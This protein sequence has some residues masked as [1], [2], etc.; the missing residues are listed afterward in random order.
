M[1]ALLNLQEYDSD[2]KDDESGNEI[3]EITSHLQPIKN[4]ANSLSSSIALVAAPA[5]VSNE[6]NLGLRHID[7]KTKEL[8][9]NPKHD[10]LFAPQV[11]PFNPFRTQQA[12]AVRN[13]LA[14]FA[15]PAHFSDFQFDNQRKTFT[16]YGFALDP[17]VDSGNV[18]ETF[19]GSES[20]VLENHGKTVFE[21]NAPIEKDKKKRKR[22]K[23]KDPSDIEGYLGP[24]A[25][26]KDEETVSRPSEEEQKELDEILAKRNKSGKQ[27]EEKTMEEKSTLHV[28]DAYDYQGRSFLHPPQD[29]GVNLKSEEPPEKC[30]LP[31][32]LIHTWTGHT[33]GIAAIRWF[34]KYAHLILSAGM[35]CKIKIWEVYKERRCIRTYTGHKQAVRDVCFNNDG[36][37]FLSCGYD[38]YCKLWDTETGECKARFT[39]RKVP[40][41]IKFH[42]E[43]DKQHL[44]VAGT[45][46][47][48]I[49]CW[50]IR[51]GEIIQEYDRHLG[52]VN[53]ITFI[54]HNRRFVST[55]DDKSLRVWEWDIPVDFKY[56]ADPSMHSMPA[57][58]LSPNGKWLACQSMDNKICVFNALNRMK[59]IRKK[60][61]TGHMV[62]GYA[63][64]IDFS[65]EMSY[66]TCGDAD[67]KVYIW[68][69]RS[70]K[71][72]SKF[73]AHDD[74]C[75]NV[76]WH[77]HETSKLAT[78]GW[79]GVIK[80]WD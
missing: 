47:K 17:S 62:A 42:P 40:Y 38:R 49:V 1:A 27:T 74:V 16:S 6:D 20:S 25:K 37:E 67:G 11:G 60:T 26:Y 12:K 70:T 66:I 61:F 53:S 68:D 10:E 33:K 45:S 54:D 43:E 4:P 48:K 28:K 13:N 19:V 75:I 8:K 58:T 65:P 73:K 24:W 5:V 29:V 72:Y 51:S 79:D 46:D 21:T 63:C 39:S 3:S 30:F 57:V 14:G 44:F 23:N 80:F 52:P 18:I 15:E 7:P 64:G 56:I 32:K 31:K 59:F 71:L 9:Y 41:C 34:P 55:S 22:E 78:A 2:D 36:K 76:L 69:W 77:P 50:D 35:D